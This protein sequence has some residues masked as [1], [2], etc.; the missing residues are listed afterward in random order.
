MASFAIK[1]AYAVMNALARQATA[2]ADIAVVDH[3][4][5]IDAQRHSQQVQKMYLTQSLEQLLQ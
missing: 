1:D 2:Q 5:F 4:S 3:Q